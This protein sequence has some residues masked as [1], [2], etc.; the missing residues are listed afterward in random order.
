MVRTVSAG[1]LAE[2]LR[3]AKN[4][5]RLKILTAKKHYYNSLV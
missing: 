3:A 1:F 5:V 4:I 2:S